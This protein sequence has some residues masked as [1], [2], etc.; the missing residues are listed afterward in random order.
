MLSH[1][2]VHTLI[3][4]HLAALLLALFAAGVQAQ[5]LDVDLVNNAGIMNLKSPEAQV[6][7]AGQPSQEQF[8]ALASAGVKHVINL[9]PASEMEFD[10]RAVVESIGMMYHSIPISGAEDIT[11]ENAAA[12]S[13]MLSAL[14]GQPVLIHCASGNRVGALVAVSAADTQGMSVD[15]AVAEGQR[16]G[17]TRLESAVRATLSDN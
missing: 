10:E 6:I 2:T 15:A 7:S 3:L 17:L 8:Q 12:L 9:R 14:S 4:R 5:S 13:E 1:S 16:W 11:H